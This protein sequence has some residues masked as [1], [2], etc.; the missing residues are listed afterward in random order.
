VSD[1]YA[2]PIEHPISVAAR[3]QDPSLQPIFT[4]PQRTASELGPTLNVSARDP[5]GYAHEGYVKLEFNVGDLL[6]HGARLYPDQGA[7]LSDSWIVTAPEGSL[8][9]RT[10]TSLS[11]EQVRT[12]TTGTTSTAASDAQAAKVETYVRGALRTGASAGKTA[13]LG[14]PGSD[15]R[16]GGAPPPPPSHTSGITGSLGGH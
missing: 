15:P 14:T 13:A 2:T 10:V 11:G 8:P 1:P 16:G 9:F 5:I 7:A 6:A 3:E 12:G 4:A